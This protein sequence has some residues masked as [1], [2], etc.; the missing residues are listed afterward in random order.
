MIYKICPLLIW[1]EAECQGS[2]PGAGIDRRD[3]YIHFSTAGQLRET[4]ARHFAGQEGLALVAVDESVL[5]PALKWEPARDG[6]FF[7]HLYGDLTLAAVRWVKPLPLD[8]DGRHLFPDL[9]IEADGRV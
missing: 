5:G 1:R 3:G 2:F 7:P 9:A 4:A 8:A 6:S